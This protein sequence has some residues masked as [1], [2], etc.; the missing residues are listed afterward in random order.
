MEH[1]KWIHFLHFSHSKTKVSAAASQ[2]G[3]LPLSVGA[4]ISFTIV[5]CFIKQNNKLQIVRLSTQFNSTIPYDKCIR[6]STMI[7]YRLPGPTQTVLGEA[8]K[9]VGRKMVQN[10][11]KKYIH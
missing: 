2:Q 1:A 9:E 10:S 6:S 5:I 3:Q 11:K 7:W 8:S 4:I